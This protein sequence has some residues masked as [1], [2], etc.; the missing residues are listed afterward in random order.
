M[1]WMLPNWINNVNR[2]LGKEHPNTKEIEK[3]KIIKNR[4]NKL[5]L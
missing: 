3:L 5:Y 2:K 4:K 1:R